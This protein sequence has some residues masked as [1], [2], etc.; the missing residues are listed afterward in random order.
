MNQF[1]FCNLCEYYV[2]YLFIFVCSGNPGYGGGYE[3]FEPETSTDSSG[4]TELQDPAQKSQIRIDVMQATIDSDE[5]GSS[6]FGRNEDEDDDV[7]DIED[8]EKS[9]PSTQLRRVKS[10]A[11]PGNFIGQLSSFLPCCVS[12]PQWTSLALG[13]FS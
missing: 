8:L 3:T 11:R 10:L 2:F 1:V 13:Y 9:L 5:P 6:Y 4:H 12:Q 7:S